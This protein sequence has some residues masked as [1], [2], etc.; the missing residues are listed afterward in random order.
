MEHL[1]THQQL[2]AYL[3]LIKDQPKYPVM[4]DK[5][6]RVMSLPPIINS[7][8]SKMTVD[9][10]NVFIDVTGTDYTKTHLVCNTLVAMFSCYCNDK[11]S[12]EPVTVEYESDHPKMGGKA[13]ICATMTPTP[14]EADPERI[15]KAL[16]LAD[17]IS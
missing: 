10:K 2:R 4:L 3:H 11:F 13:E 7:K 5:H 15:R 1:A 17:D 6:R 12:C 14:W 16:D 8:L 9:T